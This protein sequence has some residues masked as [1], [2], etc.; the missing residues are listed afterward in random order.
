MNTPNLLKQ[1]YLL[2]ILS[3]L[4]LS[5]CS[6]TEDT[7]ENEAACEF[8]LAGLSYQ[9]NDNS[10]EYTATLEDD[11]TGVKS[12]I[13]IDQATYDHYKAITENQSANICWKGTPQ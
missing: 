2:P 6:K 5:S 8:Y 3:I 7:M 9:C 13:S 10:C 12:E 4:C 11:S 1:A